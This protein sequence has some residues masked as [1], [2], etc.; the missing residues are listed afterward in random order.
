MA[1]GS[2]SVY[3]GTLLFRELTFSQVGVTA[4]AD[5]ILVSF[6]RGLYSAINT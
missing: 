5:Q 2:T 4:A 1:L 3:V 6:Q